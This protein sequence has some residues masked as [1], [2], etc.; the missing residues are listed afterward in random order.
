M[1]IELKS[2]L[3][4]ELL[5]LG[6]KRRVLVTLST[7][8][9]RLQQTNSRQPAE[10][11]LS[12]RDISGSSLSRVKNQAANAF[13]TIHSYAKDKSG[14]RH[15][16]ELLLQ[17]DKYDTYEENSEHAQAWHSQIKV[18]LNI[19][20][21]SE[22]QRKPLLVFVNPQA[23]AGNAM[24]IFNKRALTILNEANVPHVLVLTGELPMPQPAFK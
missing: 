15:R 3:S 8:D 18:L 23:G 1:K 5:D 10:R 6:Q 12:L 21:G 2:V 16:D 17:F 14:K 7:T 19:N 20:V 11:L 22:E 13:L 4:D 24:N 9:I